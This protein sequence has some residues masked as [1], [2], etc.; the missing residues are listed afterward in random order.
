MLDTDKSALKMGRYNV[1][2]ECKQRVTQKFRLRI[3]GA[4]MSHQFSL[5]CRPN[6]GA[7]DFEGAHQPVDDILHFSNLGKIVS[8]SSRPEQKEDDLNSTDDG[9]ASEESHGASNE[10]QLGLELDLL[11]PLDLVEGGC[12]KVDLDNLQPRLW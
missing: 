11:V 12:V 4:N 10:T 3:F 1:V 7:F 2:Q 6:V 9:E 5:H 8:A